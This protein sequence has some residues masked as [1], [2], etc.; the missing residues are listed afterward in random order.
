[1]SG[2]RR[3]MAAL[4]RARADLDRQRPRR[5]NPDLSLDDV[6]GQDDAKLALREAA[7]EGRNV[8]LTGPPDSGKVHVDPGGTTQFFV[9]RRGD[10]EQT[11]QDFAPA[12]P[13]RSGY[14]HWA[15][16]VAGRVPYRFTNEQRLGNVAILEAVVRS[17]E[18]A[19][20]E[21][22]AQYA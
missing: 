16:A 20:P 4:D 11:R 18:T 22:V 15:D 7:R 14:E 10:K 2:L 19:K 8:L 17:A 5:R 9:R 13:V 21:A 1:M 3:A 12:S 6:R